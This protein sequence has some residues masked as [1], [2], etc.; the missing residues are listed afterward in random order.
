MFYFLD[1][2]TLFLSKNI[3]LFT[4]NRTQSVIIQF[5]SFSKG[6]VNTYHNRSFVIV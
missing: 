3:F 5:P 1:G 6:V 2:I 4:V